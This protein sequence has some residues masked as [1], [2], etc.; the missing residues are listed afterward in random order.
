MLAMCVCV[1]VCGICLYARENSGLL[2]GRPEIMCR[3]RLRVVVCFFVKLPN[4]DG[5]M[6]VE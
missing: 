4:W 3:K 6:E 1:C 2:S 5:A